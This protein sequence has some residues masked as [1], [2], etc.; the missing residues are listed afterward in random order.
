[1]LALVHHRVLERFFGDAVL[2]GDVGRCW[3]APAATAT[4][5]TTA[6][7]AAAGA[8]WIRQRFALVRW[9]LRLRGEE[10]LLA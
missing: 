9:K 7:A 8:E 4:A 6:T 10:L 1:M 3:I 5:A 2:F